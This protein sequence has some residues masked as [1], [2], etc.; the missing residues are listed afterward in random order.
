M[1]SLSVGTAAFSGF[2]IIAKR[3]WLLLAW[4][5]M[6]LGAFILVAII[7]GILA[8]I[9]GI[10]AFAGMTPEAARD[11]AAMA[12]M[13]M[14]LIPAYIVMLLLMMFVG[15]VFTA[16]VYRAVIEP[17]KVGF[18]YTQIGGDELRQ[19]GAS[20]AI[21]IPMMIAYIIVGL[22]FALL[23][24]LVGAV[25]APAFGALIVVVGVFAVMTFLMVRFSLAGPQTFGD[26][27]L[28]LTGTWA[29]TRGHFWS[30]FAAYLIP[31]LVLFG[32]FVAI[33]VI[34]IAFIAG[35]VGISAIQ[36]L[37]SN[38]GAVAGAALGMI[39]ILLLFYFVVYPLLMVLSMTATSA[40]P[41]S[42]YK[43][44]AQKGPEAV[45]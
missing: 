32:I 3:P 20:L 21:G 2:S 1:S 28:N 39:G 30:I 31:G 42:V 27:R 11:P 16:A 45:F 40:P 41:A 25:T 44:L 7:F 15:S 19:F 12:A 6:F 37:E 17:G 5:L 13:F 43:Q 9:S 34:I 36:N 29:L 10:G 18:A 33:F 26:H 23:G 8:A 38:P 22:V 24:G 4:A 14:P 35:T